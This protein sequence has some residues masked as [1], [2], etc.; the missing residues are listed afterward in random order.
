MIIGVLIGLVIG[1]GI[2]I[3][4][5]FINKSKK[6]TIKVELSEEEKAKQKELKKSFDEL[7]K[8]DYTIAIRRG[9]R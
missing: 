5:Y 8:Y 1:L 9:D 4:L 3:V 6:P 7:M 2:G